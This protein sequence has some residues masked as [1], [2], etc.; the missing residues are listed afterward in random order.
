MSSGPKQT[1][2][3]TGKWGMVIDQDLCM[4]CQACVTACAMENNIPFIGELTMV[5]GV[6]CI[7]S[8]P[9]AFGMVPI[10]T[11]QPDISPCCASSAVMP[12]VNQSA[13]SLPRSTANPNRSIYRFITAV[14]APVIVPTTAHTRYEHL[15]GGTGLAPYR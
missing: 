2:D 8:A 3:Q 10:P 5:T 14:W 1:A 11:Y 13:R 15:T 9:N 12:P 7:G 4:G 6:V